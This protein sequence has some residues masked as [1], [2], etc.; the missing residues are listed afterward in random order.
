MEE[1]YILFRSIIANTQTKNL[2]Y[3]Y[4]KIDW[5]Q[6]LVA[7]VGTRGVGKTTLLL[8][9][10][11]LAHSLEDSLY[12]SADHFYFTE[13]RIYDLATTFVQNGGKNLFI[14]EVHKY[15]NWSKE[16]KMMY[17]YFPNLNIVFTGSSIL[18]IYRG[19]DDLSRRAILYNLQGLSFREYINFTQNVNLKSFT[20]EEIL[21]CKVEIDIE[22]PLLHFK[23][24]IKNGYF[25]FLKEKNYE[26]RLRNILLLT[27]EV[28]IPYFANMN[29]STARKIKQLLY[30]LAQNVPF[31]PNYVHLAEII[32]VNRNQVADFLYYLEKAGI[33]MQLHDGSK[34]L[35]Q[36][37]KPEKIYL[38]NTNLMYALCENNSNLGTIRETFFMNQLST[39]NKVTSSKTGDFSINDTIFEIGGKSKSNFQVKNEI[40]GFVVKDDIEFGYKK[41]LPLWWFGF[42]Y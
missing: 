27:L 35:R 23:K 18:D 6:R 3:L 10:I 21:K 5:S 36:I 11:K 32:N 29:V 17:D 8:Q 13:N 14:D 28:D 41:T 16:V 39:I 26:E 31:K 25:P 34:G 4:D 40:E 42:L 38:N 9:R 15:E 30:H 37:S 1:I 7:V 2:R 24:Y 12:I 22:T 19:S 33:I 20:L